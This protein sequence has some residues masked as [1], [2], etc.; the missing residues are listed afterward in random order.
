MSLEILVQEWTAVGPV[1][2]VRREHMRE[3]WPVLAEA[4]DR[5]SNPVPRQRQPA[6]PVEAAVLVACLVRMYGDRHD[7]HPGITSA[8]VTER[9]LVEV[10]P[11]ALT[12]LVEPSTGAM[13]LRHRG[14][15]FPD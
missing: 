3:W 9:D 4:L 11:G 10:D 8:T 1:Q 5:L 6:G 13:Y 12:V 14:I 7:D 2:E 15:P